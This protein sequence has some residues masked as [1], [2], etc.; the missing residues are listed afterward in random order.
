MKK[1]FISHK[2]LCYIHK[3]YKTYNVDKFCSVLILF[4][5]TFEINY[6]S[7]GLFYNSIFHITSS[8]K[9]I[10]GLCLFMAKRFITGF[11]NAR[12]EL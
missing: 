12:V 2:K 6:Y 10:R 11:V 1:M 5:D 7:R 9:R 4:L 3:K 8:R